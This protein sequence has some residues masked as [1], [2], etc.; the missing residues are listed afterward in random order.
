VRTFSALGH[1]DGLHMNPATHLLWALADEDGNPHLTTIDPATGA[2]Q[3]YQFATTAHSGGFDD[4]AFAQ[5]MSFMDASNPTLDKSGNNVF[6][7]LDTVRLS[8]GQVQVTTLLMGNATSTDITAG[9]NKN[10][11]LNLV[12]P[13]SLTFDPSGDLVLDNQAGTQLVF[14]KGA[15]TSHQTVRSLMIGDAVD[16]SLW[17]TASAGSFLISDTK[18]NVIYALHSTSYSRSTLYATTP[19]DSGVAGFVGTIDLASG[20]ITPVAIGL[21]SPHGMVFLPEGM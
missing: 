7:A 16:D 14:I 1:L 12:D 11:T 10:V 8:H 20:I 4:M 13:D 15:G 18:A 2:T 3:L 19:N 17:P 5:G 6:P 9:N 21:I